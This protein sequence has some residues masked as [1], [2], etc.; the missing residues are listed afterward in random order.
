M[1]FLLGW[2]Q[3]SVGKICELFWQFGAKKLKLLGRLVAPQNSK[4]PALAW[5]DESGSRRMCPT[6][7]SWIASSNARIGPTGQALVALIIET[8]LL[9]AVSDLPGWNRIGESRVEP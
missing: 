1:I 5:L 8:G 6:L 9:R 4:Q 7:R 3:R 2:K